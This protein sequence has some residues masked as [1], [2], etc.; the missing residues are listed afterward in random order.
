MFII[1]VL[2]FRNSICLSTAGFEKYNAGTFVLLSM[3][4]CHLFHQCF[5]KEIMY[6]QLHSSSKG[7]CI[8][9]I[10]T[11]ISLTFNVFNTS[12]KIR[13]GENRKTEI[14]NEGGGGGGFL[15]MY[16]STIICNGGQRGWGSWGVPL[17]PCH[18]ALAALTALH[19]NVRNLRFLL[20]EFT[21]S[22]IQQGV[23]ARGGRIQQTARI[24]LV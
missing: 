16:L 22:I 17:C 6:E 7:I 9:S 12:R 18:A 10:L 5:L 23:T 4:Y 24:G 15:F 19:P 11:F 14:Q 3:M 21:N 13:G 1:F 8:A 20:V 2:F